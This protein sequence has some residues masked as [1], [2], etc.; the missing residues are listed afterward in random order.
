MKLKTPQFNRL[1]AKMSLFSLASMLLLSVMVY[2][3]VESD[4]KNRQQT[5][6]LEIITKLYNEYD[7]VSQLR[8]MELSDSLHQK[9]KR[10]QNDL[11]VKSIKIVNYEEIND[12][13]F[14]DMLIIPQNANPTNEFFL[15]SDRKI[16]GSNYMLYSLSFVVLFLLLFLSSIIFRFVRK[17]IL[18]PFNILISN[19]E[20]NNGEGR[21]GE[22]AKGEF[23]QLISHFNKLVKIRA[24][25]ETTRQLVHDIK[26]P[27]TTLSI[28]LEDVQPKLDKE[29]S[30]LLNLTLNRVENILDTSQK[31]YKNV[32]LSRLIKEIILEKEVEDSA[33]EII[34]HNHLLRNEQ[35]FKCCESDFKRAISNLINNSIEASH[36][37]K[38]VV[39]IDLFKSRGN[40]VI[41]ISDNG[42]GIAD[43]IINDVLK[44]DYTTKD[45][46]NG[47]GL[48]FAKS[49]TEDNEGSLK[50]S[51]ELNKG[52]TVELY[53]PN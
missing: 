31:E 52:T 1:I 45:H 30:N 33:V 50:I 36:G 12:R 7:K 44:V 24:K 27:L 23:K 9:L 53:L 25:S 29:Q 10:I 13:A 37:S 34:F 42:C 18:N 46:G 14:R 38:L 16:V 6:D 49:F 35:K 15:V 48:S 19:L 51:S 17:E 2:S 43:D 41:S 32:F 28:L 11:N 26:S 40:Y 4:R 47:L 21:L 20:E 3:F 8:S 39:N 22:V 5:K